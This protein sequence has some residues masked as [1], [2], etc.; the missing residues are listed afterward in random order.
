MG[1]DWQNVHKIAALTLWISLTFAA[2][3]SFQVF[4]AVD[5]AQP[6]GTRGAFDVVEVDSAT[7]EA[8]LEAI[9]TTAKSLG[10]NI[11]KIQSDPHGSAQ[12]RTLFAFIGNLAGFESHGGYD[13]PTFSPQAMTTEVAPADEITTQDLRGKYVTD[14][15]TGQMDQ[16]L[17][18]LGEAGVHAES[19]SVS[20]IGLVL[21]S[22]GQG[23]LAGPFVVMALALGLAIA[24]SVSRNRKVYA[25]RA[26]HGYRTAASVRAEVATYT[27]TYGA[28]LATLL[29]VGTPLLGAYNGFRQGLGFLRILAITIVI[30]YLAVVVLVALAVLSVPQRH[31]PEILKGEQASVRDGVLAAGA[32]VA[33]LAIVV[34]T[35]SAAMTRVESVD[36][37]MGELSRWSDGDPLYA[38]RLSTSG[39]HEDDL[40]DAPSLSAV[41]ANMERAGQVL[42][43]GYKGGL[44]EDGAASSVEPEGTR[45]LIVNNEYLDRQAV[46]G[47]DGERVQDVPGGKDRFTLLVPESYEGDPEVLLRDYV[48]Y[49][50]SF[51][52]TIGRQDESA[53][54]DPVGTVVRTKP[55]QDLFTYNGT[56]F[57]PVQMQ[58]RMFVH[59]PVVAVVSADSELISPM[60]YLSYSSRDDVLFADPEVLDRELQ[61][62]GVRGSFQGIDNA[63]DAVTV[64]V[65]LARSQLRMDVFSLALGWAVLVLSS[66]V[67]V[68]VYCD[69]RKR[70][71]FVE[72]IHGYPF[73]RRHWQYLV[74]AVALS[75]MGVSVAGVAGGSLAHGRDMVAAAAFVAIQFSV[76]LVAIKTYETRFRADFIKR[77]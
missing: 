69:R 44:N 21:Y 31:I 60:E 66:V 57:L 67:M 9:E 5:E 64:S 10:I 33:V 45:S 24:Y 25:L 52:C 35:T 61:A 42:F 49:F 62:Q 20:P 58:E 23:N 55:G 76:S 77:Y 15:S 8:A 29:V 56:A 18:M 48:D 12:G 53:S 59:D 22:V 46:M 41:I 37:T 50:S 70:P 73:A 68:A 19:S 34:A 1:K 63:A 6:A 13:Y 71:M 27:V 40:R 75:L 43:V 30:L 16:V 47:A 54:C 39:T 28:G 65:A 72:V 51:A 14:A 26:L 32:Q 11:F 36:A 3:V 4:V 38:L 74:G 7:K 2:I 17:E